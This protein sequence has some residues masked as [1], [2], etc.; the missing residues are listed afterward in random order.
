MLPMLTQQ[1]KITQ[2]E[3]TW[4]KAKFITAKSVGAFSQTVYKIL[5]VIST[6]VFIFFIVFFF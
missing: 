4:Y 2:S 5:L 1:Q 3:E 6:C